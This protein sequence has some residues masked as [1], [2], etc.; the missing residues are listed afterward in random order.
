[1]SFAPLL[2]LGGAAVVIL[3]GK[4]KKKSSVSTSTSVCESPVTVSKDSIPMVAVPYLWDSGEEHSSGEPIIMEYEKDVPKVAYD[5]VKGG[6]RNI[7]DITKKTLAHVIR[8]SCVGYPSIVVNV[9]TEDG[10]TWKN[11]APEF[12]YGWGMTIIP[13]LEIVDAISEQEA[14][15]FVE[16]LKKWWHDHMGD[17]HTPAG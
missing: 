2:L 11:S 17:T 8:G 12:F 9:K 4:K 1:M 6:N 7:V 14:D 16:V 3:G 13:L 5:E 10:N 15:Q